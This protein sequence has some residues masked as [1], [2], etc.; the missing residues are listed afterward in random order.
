M[1]TYRSLASAPSIFRVNS[2]G[3]WV[4]L[5][6]VQLVHWSKSTLSLIKA[7]LTRF[8]PLP[9]SQCTSADMKSAFAADR[10]CS[11]RIFTVPRRINL[12]T[13]TVDNV[14]L[15]A[16]NFREGFPRNMITS[17]KV[18]YIIPLTSH[19]LATDGFCVQQQLVYTLLSGFRLPWPPSCCLNEST[20]FRGSDE[21]IV[22]HRNV[23]SGSSRIASSASLCSDSWIIGMEYTL[24]R[25]K[26]AHQ[27]LLSVHSSIRRLAAWLSLPEIA[28]AIRHTVR[29]PRNSMMLPPLRRGD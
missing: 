29:F 3:R 7:F 8:Y 27:R 10:P 14:S 11:N 21:R 23:T 6:P 18:P 1:V 4:V 20:P 12:A 17:P 22:W 16:M 15:V 13:N 25:L 9:S 24:S 5:F 26:S 19:G 2:F 28:F